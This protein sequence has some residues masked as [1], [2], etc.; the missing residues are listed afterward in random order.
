MKTT[1]SWPTSSTPVKS[2]FKKS[3]PR[4]R[5]RREDNADIVSCLFQAQG[6]EPAA[7]L[8]AQVERLRVVAAVS[9]QVV[10]RLSLSCC[11]ILARG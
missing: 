4:G 2:F 6:L 3:R 9:S 11:L 5:R 7:V 1:K 8:V 10:V